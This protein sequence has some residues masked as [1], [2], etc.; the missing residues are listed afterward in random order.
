MLIQPC[1]SNLIAN[2]CTTGSRNSSHT[3]YLSISLVSDGV[4]GF[5][6]FPQN[7]D[8]GK[9][10]HRWS[11]SHGKL[12]ESKEHYASNLWSLIGRSPHLYLFTLLDRCTLQNNRVLMSSWCLYRPISA[13]GLR[14]FIL[15]ELPREITH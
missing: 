3:C 12:F 13:Q 2:I 15:N 9:G 14:S 1:N 10:I 7:G 11:G 5:I 6:Q 8:N 4:P